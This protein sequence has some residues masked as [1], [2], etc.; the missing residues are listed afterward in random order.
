MVDVVIQKKQWKLATPGFGQLTRVTHF[1]FRGKFFTQ[2]KI[3]T[4]VLP[5]P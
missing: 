5:L 1:D 4:L 3:F 2:N